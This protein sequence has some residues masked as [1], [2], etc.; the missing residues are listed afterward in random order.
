[1]ELSSTSVPS[2][3]SAWSIWAGNHP[4]DGFFLQLYDGQAHLPLFLPYSQ[5]QSIVLSDVDRNGV[6]E[7]WQVTTV[8]SSF[9]EH[10][11]SEFP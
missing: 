1:V 11:E 5:I 10:P 7:Q 9:I 6:F 3:L 4:T 2:L 8:Q